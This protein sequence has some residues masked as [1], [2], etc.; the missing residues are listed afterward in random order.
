M[1]TCACLVVANHSALRTSRRNVPSKCSCPSPLKLGHY[2]GRER[3]EGQAGAYKVAPPAIIGT[4]EYSYL[5]FVAGWDILFFG[6]ALNNATLAG[7]AMIVVAGAMVL[8][9]KAATE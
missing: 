9:S 7:M 3:G 8:L 4:F 1:T 5:V 2:D 6:T